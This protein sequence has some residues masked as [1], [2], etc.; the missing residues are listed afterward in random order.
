M[1]CSVTERLPRRRNEM[2]VEK[3]RIMDQIIDSKTLAFH[4]CQWFSA[5]VP[6]SYCITDYVLQSNLV[7][8]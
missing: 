4:Q 3:K 1:F 8:E 5:W 2:C 6:S 7:Y